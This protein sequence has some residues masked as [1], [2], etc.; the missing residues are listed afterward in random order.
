MP[1]I[2]LAIAVVI[3]GLSSA[4]WVQTA[5][6]DIV[7]ANYAAFAA[8]AEVQGKLALKDKETKEKEHAELKEEADKDNKDRRLDIVALVKRLHDTEGT[9]RSTLPPDTRPPGSTEA[10]RIC[11]DRDELDRAQ[12]ESEVEAEAIAIRGAEAVVDWQT[13]QKWSCKL[14]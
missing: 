6:L 12:S 8:G 1:Y 10:V 14:K 5:R 11:F 9:N 4:L 2:L 3:A 7:T 13:V